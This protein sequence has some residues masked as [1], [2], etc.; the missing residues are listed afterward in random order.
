MQ[1]RGIPTI[2]E[3]RHVRMATSDSPDTAARTCAVVSASHIR[4]SSCRQILAADAVGGLISPRPGRRGESGRPRGA[5]GG[6]LAREAWRGA[7]Q[8]QRGMQ[9]SAGHPARR[10]RHTCD[11][12]QILVKGI[13]AL[14]IFPLADRSGSRGRSSRGFGGSLGGARLPMSRRQGGRTGGEA[15]LEARQPGSPGRPFV[16]VCISEQKGRQAN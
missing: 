14:S 16:A 4:A 9:G 8:R 13:S 12:R 5:R 10:K 15:L 2:P 7:W 11:S 1:V 3:Y 6:S